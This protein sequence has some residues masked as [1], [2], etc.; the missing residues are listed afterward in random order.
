MNFVTEVSSI[1]YENWC[2]TMVRENFQIYGVQITG[3]KIASQKIESTYAPP[4]KCLLKFLSSSPS[5]GK[6]LIPKAKFFQ[7]YFSHNRKR[8][9]ETT[10]SSFLQLS[11]KLLQF[12]T[13]HVFD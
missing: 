7:I 9:E 13:N 11:I 8:R 3:K 4:V 2:L 5:G 12:Q 6:L 1:F 10:A